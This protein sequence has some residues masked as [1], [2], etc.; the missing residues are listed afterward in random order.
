[1]G[2]KNGDFIKGGNKYILFMG[3]FVHLFLVFPD[4][5]LMAWLKCNYV[6]IEEDVR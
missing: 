2:L 6:V 5:R 4:I 3:G 1:M